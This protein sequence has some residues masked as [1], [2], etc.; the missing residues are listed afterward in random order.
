MT[1]L[2]KP[3]T[4][5]IIE[6]ENK[7]SYQVLGTV[8]SIQYVYPLSTI[9]LSVS[10]KTRDL[11]NKFP[12][13]MTCVLD[14]YDSSKVNNTKFN[15][16]RRYLHNLYELSNYAVN[17]YERCLIVSEF[18][19]MIN[20]IEIPDCIEDI[21]F[22]YVNKYF[23]GHNEETQ[24]QEYSFE[25]IFMNNLEFITKLYNF[26]KETYNIDISNCDGPYKEILTKDY[27]KLPLGLKKKF[28]IECFLHQ[29]SLLTSEDFCGFTNGVKLSEITKDYKF[30]DKYISF[31]GLRLYELDP[32][33]KKWNTAILQHLTAF[34]N[35][36]VPAITIKFY[37]DRLRFNTPIKNAIGVWSRRES[38][39][40]LYQLIEYYLENYS[41]FFTKHEANIEYFNICARV[42]YD[43][44][45]IS[46]LKQ[47][48]MFFGNIYLFNS[49]PEVKTELD[50]FIRV[51][52]YF[53]FHYA[54]YPID[55]HKFRTDNDI[56]TNKR[57][58]DKLAVS[59]VIKNG[60]TRYP[61]TG[62]RGMLYKTLL[63]LLHTHKYAHM[64]T[65]DLGLMMTLIGAGTIPIL[66]NAPDQPFNLLK[67]GK[68]YLLA[69]KDAKPLTK[70][71]YETM[72][73]NLNDFYEEYLHPEKTL[74]TLM[75]Y[76]FVRDIE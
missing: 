42:L 44:P 7:S 43:K 40:G 27:I 55:L 1:D 70:K 66:K 8:L 76:F 48:M 14:Y 65:H 58:T 52:N 34:N 41:E 74:R 11:I 71:K 68:H 21:G 62:R 67:E 26:V 45:D 22:G 24:S 39:S 73:K 60:K 5:V 59:K 37:S 28:E 35:F 64:K 72:R 46:C 16:I 13:N 31:M 10:N 15:L 61:A 57:I 30:N 75:H 33:I 36:V 53:V 56:L 38:P 54:D 17:K 6:S 3:L 12:L 25:L 47:T 9:V 4:F 18:L 49:G 32:Q 63:K 50:K 51:K 69:K 2:K 19:L 23:K 29:Q 20:E